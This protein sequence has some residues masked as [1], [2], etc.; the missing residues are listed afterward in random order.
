M[1]NKDLLK[2]PI[3][4]LDLYSIDG[5][6]QL[7]RGFEAAFFQG[8]NLA[9]PRIVLENMQKDEGTTI[10]LSIAG[11]V[12]PGGLRKLARDTIMNHRVDEPVSVGSNLVYG[13]A[14]KKLKPKNTRAVCVGGDVSKNH[15]QQLEPLLDTMGYGEGGGHKHAVRITTGDPKW[16]GLNGCTIAAVYRQLHRIAAHCGRVYTIQ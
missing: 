1:E 11:A 2:H 10:F 5:L 6:D 16:G 3:Q 12:V 14:Q 15:I 7:L 8:R 4:H 9:K 13:T